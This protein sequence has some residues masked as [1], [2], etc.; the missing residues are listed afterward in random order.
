M[1]LVF[2]QQLA[3]ALGL[4]LLVGFQRE[5][6]APH[7]AGLRTFA[8]ITVLGTLVGQF[9]AEAGGWLISAGLVAVAA[10]LIVGGLVK[11]AGTEKRPGLTTQIAAL[12]MYLVG[13]AVA[14]GRLELG[15]VVAGGTAVLLHWK[16]PL[17]TFVE[18]IGEADARA[19]FQLVLIALVILPVLPDQSFDPYGVLNPFEIWLVVVLIVGISLGGYI[20]YKFVGARAGTLV[21][22]ILGGLISST[23]TTVSY[24][25]RARR[26]PELIQL[27][28]AVILIASTIVF[29]RVLVE[30]AVVA[31]DVFW[32]LVPPL[33]V[34]MGLMAVISGVLF[35]LRRGE[36]APPELDDDPS[37]LRTAI[38][39]GLLYAAVLFAVAAVKEH[40]GHQALYVVAGLSGLT[41]MDAITLSTA[42]MVSKQRLDADTGWRMILIGAL[43]NLVFKAAAAG[44]LGGRWLLLRLAAA[45]GIALVGGTLLL[46]LWP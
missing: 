44:L 1:D 34:M 30:V 14:L 42:Q 10:M 21:G 15:I 26:N 24:A 3:V 27:A 17:H 16:R 33:A 20:C 18:R 23:A 22:G 46:V 31:P 37:E 5:W 29:G 8:L 13:V 9:V 39:F 35:L 25:R 19:I 28:A 6:T 36:S 43:S 11:F 2:I 7:V 41:D 38:V 40:F 45:F 12:L 4:G 32:D